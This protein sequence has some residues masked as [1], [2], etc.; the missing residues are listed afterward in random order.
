MLTKQQGHIATR[1]QVATNTIFRV[2]DN[3]VNSKWR[4]KKEYEE[5]SL[6][7]SLCC[8]KYCNVAISMYRGTLCHLKVFAALRNCVR[9]WKCYLYVEMRVSLVC[10]KSEADSVLEETCA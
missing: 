7:T 2:T 3:T 1:L 4:E 6:V 10:I 9:Y 8:T 5:Y